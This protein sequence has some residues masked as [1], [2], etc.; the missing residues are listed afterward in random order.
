MD[1]LISTRRGAWA[2]QGARVSGRRPPPAISRDFSGAAAPVIA[3]GLGGCSRRGRSADRELWSQGRV[4][5]HADRPVG[6]ARIGRHAGRGHITAR[7]KPQPWLRHAR[8][9]PTDTA[10]VAPT[11]A[12]V[13][14]T[15]AR[16]Q[17]GL[18]L[19]AAAAVEAPAAVEAGE[20]FAL[21]SRR[22]GLLVR[23][24]PPNIARGDVARAFAGYL[25][26]GSVAERCVACGSG[27]WRRAH[28]T[29]PLL[30]RS[31]AS[32]RSPSR[33]STPRLTRQ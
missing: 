32:P 30:P 5:T 31:P 10:S 3:A 8:G 19:S 4:E 12:V 33:S 22:R 20:K 28:V 15:R 7:Y 13:M 2:L 21:R 1:G 26:A 23:N 17:G 25:L 6:R 16:A 9:V 18:I 11:G 29:P 24:L 27:P 14:R